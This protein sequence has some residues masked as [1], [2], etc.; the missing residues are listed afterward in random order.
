[1]LKTSIIVGGKLQTDTWKLQPLVANYSIRL[2]FALTGCN[3][4]CT[5][6]SRLLT[7]PLN[8]L[9]F[10]AHSGPVPLESQLYGLYGPFKALD[11]ENIDPSPKPIP[12]EAQTQIYIPY[13]PSPNL[14]PI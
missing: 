6:V 9:S 7:K 4:H 1:M 2:Q 14:N 8:L 5:R 10:L 11:S 13:N 3:F 12:Q